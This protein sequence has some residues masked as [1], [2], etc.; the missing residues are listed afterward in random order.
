MLSQGSLPTARIAD[1]V[2]APARLVER[3]AL[4]AR[5]DL[6][7]SARIS[8]IHAPAGYGKSVLLNAWAQK[9][10]GES[11]DVAWINANEELAEPGQFL[12]ALITSTAGSRSPSH[13]SSRSDL[14][15]LPS[16]SPRPTIRRF[17]AALTERAYPL[18]IIIDA[19]ERASNDELDVI[20]GELLR[21]APSQ[22]HFAIATRMQ[23]RVELSELWLNSNVCE[24]SPNQLRLTDEEIALLFNHSL[25]AEGIARIS[26]WTEGWPVAVS[27]V[28]HH[29][30]A[31]KNDQSRLTQL[32]AEADG[33]ISRYLMDQM[34]LRLPDEHRELLLQTSF[35]EIISD[36]VAEAVTGLD[37]ARGILQ[38]LERSN[39]LISPVDNTGT[40][41]SCH[42]L[43]RNVLF[44]QLRRRGRR[45]LARLQ[46]VA[47]RW[48][49]A[50]GELREAIR[51]ACAVP[52]FHLVAQLMLQLGGILYGVR[53]GALAL[54]SLLE[55]L[56]PE[57]VSEYPRL[58]LAQ[59]F[60][61]VKEG[62]FDAASDL[63]RAVRRR[64]AGVAAQG[65]NS[66]DPLLARDLALAELTRAAYC[67]L[68]LGAKDLDVIEK[69]TAEASSEDYWL[70]GLLNNLLCVVQYRQSD[71]R[72]ALAT[73]ES[74]HYYYAQA[75]S[76]NG[77][78]HMHLH[79]GQIHLELAD[80]RTAITHYRAARV[81]FETS[82]FGDDAGCAIADV[83]LSEALYEQGRICEARAL[84]APALAVAESGESHYEALVAGY[85]TLTALTLADEGAL[86]AVRVLDRALALARRRRFVEVERYL[87]LRRLELELHAGEHAGVENWPAPTPVLPSGDRA[88]I[89]WREQDLKTIL[90]ARLSLQQNDRAQGIGLLEHL[91]ES[92]AQLGRVCSRTVALVELALARR[93]DG[94]QSAALAHLHE[95][96]MLAAP[97]TLLRPFFE[98]ARECLPLLSQLI[99]EHGLSTADP[100]ELDFVNKV[101]RAANEVNAVEAS[102]LSPREREIV[103]LLLG[104]TN[105]KL[106]ARALGIS[107]DT[108]RF[109]LKKIYE[110]FGVSDRRLVAEV[111]RERGLLGSPPCDL[112]SGAGGLPHSE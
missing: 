16:L 65:S 18:V 83:M 79:V 46:L 40:S 28:H 69:A 91:Q 106:I 43:L 41:Y 101:M 104:G 30:S 88:S 2:T 48:Y 47:A 110:K 58:S 36:E 99:T 77:V 105:N 53:N 37:S 34:L 5:L 17:V 100:A 66:I 23:L 96:I 85:R 97:G 24:F 98:R 15:T 44:G 90:E 62:R 38:D 39:I 35:L 25:D 87:L 21:T 109:H 14:S 72:V 61:L 13:E 54:R 57:F 42:H 103:Q 9:L 3:Q 68:Y 67:G 49:Q 63:I 78:G 33:D 55:Q 19:Y 76:P 107:P 8:V 4:L 27:L 20:L 10:R 12:A 22:V 51:C 7:R 32:L 112:P 94:K 60:V 59:A 86:A 45:E 82:F 80:V 70:R 71:F 6:A 102:L 29:L 52:D 64:L 31:S 84:C 81:S 89:G 108:V 111:A 92:L 73:A 56:P 11:I 26:V 95:A 74:A 75:S 93:L 1:D 50:N